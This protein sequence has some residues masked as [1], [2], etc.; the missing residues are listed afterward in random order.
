MS[1]P[2]VTVVRAFLLREPHVQRC[3]ASAWGQ[4]TPVQR[5]NSWEVGVR[6][7][8]L[9]DWSQDRQ[10]SVGHVKDFAKHFIRTQLIRSN[11]TT[12]FNPSFSVVKTRPYMDQQIHILHLLNAGSCLLIVATLIEE[13]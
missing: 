7:A 6:E 13:V 4:R 11:K 2:P 10:S 1:K 12:S 3:G 9:I 5:L 8:V